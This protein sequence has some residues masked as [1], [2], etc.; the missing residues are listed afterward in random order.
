MAWMTRPRL[1]FLSLFS[2]PDR[3]STRLNSSHLVISYAVFC[4][5][6]KT[7]EHRRRVRRVVAGDHGE[8][9]GHERSVPEDHHPRSGSVHA[10]ELILSELQLGVIHF[11]YDVCVCD[12]LVLCVDVVDFDKRKMI[13]YVYV[14]AVFCMFMMDEVF[15]VH[16]AQ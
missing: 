2:P 9:R 14:S 15:D 10:E 7:H 8:V 13:V 6:K 3:K 16:F 5:K 4:L 11:S 12:I 1:T